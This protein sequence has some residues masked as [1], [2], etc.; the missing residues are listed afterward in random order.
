MKY[1]SDLI[2]TI[3]SL[4]DKNQKLVNF[5]CDTINIG[6]EASYRRIRG[7]VEFSASEIFTIAQKLNISLDFFLN[8]KNQENSTVLFSIY[9]NDKHDPESIYMNKVENEIQVLKPFIGK[10]TVITGAYTHLPEEMMYCHPNL[11]KLRILK[12]FSRNK[13]C[14]KGFPT[15]KD[16]EIPKELTLLIKEKIRMEHPFKKHLILGTN[17]FH[18]IISDIHYFYKLNLITSKEIF[19]LERELNKVLHQ[20]TNSSSKHTKT[21]IYTSEFVLDHSFTYIKA[22]NK[23]LAIDLYPP[24]ALI[25]PDREV[26]KIHEEYLDIIIQ[27]SVL[28]SQAGLVNKQRYM[29]QQR[30]IINTL[31]EYLS[32]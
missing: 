9:T 11:M 28:L 26:C 18:N 2:Y 20:I 30:K 12:V 3:K 25:S 24:D 8:I 32:A 7:E 10:D 19:Y 23:L 5:L 29:Q 31:H 14:I 13:A 22:D 1:Q 16:I 21:S 15:I 4:L 6:R 27:N 17:L